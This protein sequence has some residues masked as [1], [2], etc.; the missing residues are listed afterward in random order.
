MKHLAELLEDQRDMTIHSEDAVAAVAEAVRRAQ[1]RAVVFDGGL[2]DAPVGGEGAF[3]GL[4]PEKDD[5]VIMVDG[6]LEFIRFGAKRV[7]GKAC[8]M[9]LAAR[10]LNP[11]FLSY[12]ASYDVARGICQGPPS[13]CSSSSASPSSASPVT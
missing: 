11:R 9:F 1:G 5:V 3:A 13:P 6:F 7:P 12:M 8:Q 2:S 10:I 4:V